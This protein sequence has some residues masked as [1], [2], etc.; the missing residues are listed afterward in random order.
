M[1]AE[2]CF[3]HPWLCQATDKG[4]IDLPT[5]GA[6]AAPNEIPEETV[7]SRA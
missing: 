1:M 2:Q 5:F 3:C 4:F 7:A 6:E